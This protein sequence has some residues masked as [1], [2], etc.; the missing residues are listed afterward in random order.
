MIVLKK[1]EYD[2]ISA[3]G[4]PRFANYFQDHM[5]L[6]RAPQRAVVWGFGDTSRMTTLQIENNIYTTIVGHFRMPKL[7]YVLTQIPD[8]S[9]VLTR[10]SVNIVWTT[11]S[12]RCTNHNHRMRAKSRSQPSVCSQL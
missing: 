2:E 10:I 11:V 9:S 3:N 6:Q 7:K 8:S 1:E 4:L 5:V 12:F